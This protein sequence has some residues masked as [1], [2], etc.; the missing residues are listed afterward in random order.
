[1]KNRFVSF[2][3]LR[4]L[5]HASNS[6]LM[7]WRTHS[8]ETEYSKTIFRK[9]LL[10][11]H[12]DFLQSYKEQ[13]LI[14]GANLKLLNNVF[15]G[16]FPKLSLGDTRTLVFYVKPMDN[17]STPRRV[18]VALGRL[19]ESIR[20]ILE[21]IDIDLPPRPEGDTKRAAYVSSNPSEVST[22]LETLTER[23]INN[24]I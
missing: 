20:D 5:D 19:I 7:T 14:N 18:K 16:T 22:F 3:L 1:M 11:V 13:Q 23:H 17:I 21:T 4:K 24:N 10:Y 15:Y 2:I 12:P 9:F 6:I 8:T